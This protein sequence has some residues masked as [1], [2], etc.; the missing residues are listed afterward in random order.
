MNSEIQTD[1][2]EPEKTIVEQFNPLSQKKPTDFPTTIDY[3]PDDYQRKRNKKV[4]KRGRK[5]EYHNQIDAE[6]ELEI[7][8]FEEEMYR[9]E[10]E[11]IRE[12]E[13]EDEDYMQFEKKMETFL[14]DRE[15]EI[16]KGQESVSDLETEILRK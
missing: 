16:L 14:K 10:L 8:E 5:S 2:I 11:M 9:D 1:F 12:K 3:T 13:D 4:Q 6:D 15:S 7:D